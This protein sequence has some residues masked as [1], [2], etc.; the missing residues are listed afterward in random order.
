MDV[1]EAFQK[2]FAVG[3][4]LH[5]VENTNRYALR[6]IE[7]SVTSFT[8]CSRIR[9][10]LNVVVVCVTEGKTVVLFWVELLALCIFFPLKY[11]PWKGWSSWP[12]FFS[13]LVIS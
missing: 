5:A 12:S 13:S 10:W 9:N 6:Q 8:F 3:L 4:V 7:K 11:Y 1:V 2:F